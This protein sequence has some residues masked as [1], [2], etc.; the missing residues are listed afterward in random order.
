MVTFANSEVLAVDKTLPFNYRESVAS[1]AE[2]IRSQ[3]PR[4]AYP[5][6]GTLLRANARVLDFG[7]G[8]GG[9]AYS[10]S[11][12]CGCAVMGID[13]NPGAA[14]RARHVAQG[15]GV[16]TEFQVSDLFVYAPP[17]PFDLVLSLGVLHHTNNCSA[18]VRRVCDLVKPV[19][20]VFIGLYHK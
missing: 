9:L 10:M 6:L 16:H 20:H 2:A 4:L 17:Q 3:D 19:G 5:V 18:A 14:E 1:S 8:V 12:H 13:F 7:C 15:L 11:H